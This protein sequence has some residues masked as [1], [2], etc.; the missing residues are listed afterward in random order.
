[1]VDISWADKS[2][3]LPEG[4]DAPDVRID[5]KLSEDRTSSFPSAIATDMPESKK[6]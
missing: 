1:M 5:A 3:L 4:P 6:G 2:F